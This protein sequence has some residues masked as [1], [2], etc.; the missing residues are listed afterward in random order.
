MTSEAGVRGVGM[1]ASGDDL[2]RDNGDRNILIGFNRLRH[3]YIGI[4]MLRK[5]NILLE[6]QYTEVAIKF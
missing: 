4:S 3:H 2:I 6:K 1:L 5:I